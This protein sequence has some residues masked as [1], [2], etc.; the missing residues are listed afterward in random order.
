M[1][2]T[3]LA[4]ALSTLAACSGATTNAPVV[5]GGTDTP[6]ADTPTTPTDTPVDTPATPTDTPRPPTDTPVTPGDTGVREAP[7]C[8]RFYTVDTSMCRAQTFSD[9]RDCP[10]MGA[11][12]SVCSVTTVFPCGMPS[13][14]RDG[15]AFDRIADVPSPGDAAL[16]CASLCA[17]YFTSSAGVYC[18]LR[19]DED[20]GA[21]VYLMCGRACGA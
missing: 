20:G 2:P 5:D 21:A 1:K 11:P 14:D 4:L 9:Q 3:L 7:Y 8:Q 12:G 10:F 17:P 19:A 18:A 15:G 6:A 13:S 16:D